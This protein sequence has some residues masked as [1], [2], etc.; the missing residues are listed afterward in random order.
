MDDGTAGGCG[1]VI[2]ADGGVIQSPNFPNQYPNDQDCEWR[3][4]LPAG[5][6]VALNFLAFNLEQHSSCR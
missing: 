4:Q 5:Q 6:K 2:N 1:G 3:V